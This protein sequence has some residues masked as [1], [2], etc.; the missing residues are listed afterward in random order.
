[1]RVSGLPLLLVIPCVSL[2][3]KVEGVKLPDKL[4]DDDQQLRLNGAEA[5]T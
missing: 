5:A 1:M 3:T 4:V 2:E